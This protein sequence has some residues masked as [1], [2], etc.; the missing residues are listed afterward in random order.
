MQIPNAQ[1]LATISK[2]LPDNS[3]LLKHIRAAESL[4]LQSPQLQQLAKMSETLSWSYQHMQSLAKLYPQLD[5]LNNSLEMLNFP[6]KTPSKVSAPA[7]QVELEI[8][9]AT[10][11]LV[12]KV[13]EQGVI[14]DELPN[15][16]TV[17]TLV[18]VIAYF[19]TRLSPDEL[20]NWVNQLPSILLEQIKFMGNL[21][22]SGIFNFLALLGI[23]ERVYSWICSKY[24]GNRPS[25]STNHKT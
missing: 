18:F 12:N 5:K 2:R 21:T 17:Q 24:C 16:A 20:M 23:A 7:S 8:R 3:A 9:E 6:V 4:Q 11:A 10:D 25:D 14:Q 13:H 22:L 1:A 19:V 15:D